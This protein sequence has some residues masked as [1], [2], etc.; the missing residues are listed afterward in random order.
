MATCDNASSNKPNSS[1]KHNDNKH[2]S[3]S[4]S[5]GGNTRVASK[6]PEKGKATDRY[7]R[8]VVGGGTTPQG[9]GG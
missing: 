9:D 5:S 3:S 4:S 1:S 7:M 2:G 6:R 8:Y